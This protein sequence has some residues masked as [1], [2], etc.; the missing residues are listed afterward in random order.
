MRHW[1]RMPRGGRTGGNASGDA[2]RP[3]AAS[4]PKLH[5]ARQ[6]LRWWA[7][8][9][10]WLSAHFA[11]CNCFGTNLFALPLPFLQPFGT[12]RAQTS[13][14]FPRPLIPRRAEV[15]VDGGYFIYA[16][17]KAIPWCDRAGRSG[18]HLVG[19]PANVF[20]NRGRNRWRLTRPG[21]ATGLSGTTGTCTSEHQP[22]S[23]GAEHGR[24][25]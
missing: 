21:S 9:P 18:R 10:D 14:G 16:Q 8:R 5:I 1:E 15:G 24:R 4:R 19:C 12:D 3:R 11:L 25:A 13:V 2:R 23:T 17:V 20:G 6:N 22:G 7:C